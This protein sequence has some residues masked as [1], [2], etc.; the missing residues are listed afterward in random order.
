M[1]SFVP[2]TVNPGRDFIEAFTTGL[3]IGRGLKKRAAHNQVGKATGEAYTLYRQ[4]REDPAKVTSENM[5]KV[6][7]L[8]GVA[9]S[10]APKAGLSPREIEKMFPQWDEMLLDRTT[11]LARVAVASGLNSDEGVASVA[12]ITTLLSGK[13]PEAI[14][15]QDDGSMIVVPGGAKSEE[16]VMVLNEQD[17]TDL[18]DSLSEGGV[19]MS[20]MQVQLRQANDSSA[21]GRGAP[22]SGALESLAALEGDAAQVL[23]NRER[24]ADRAS[25][26]Q[27]VRI[28]AG[29]DLKTNQNTTDASLART[30][31]NDRATQ[32]R[33][34]ANIRTTSTSQLNSKRGAIEDRRATEQRAAEAEQLSLDKKAQREQTAAIQARADR[35]AYDQMEIDR[36]KADASMLTAQTGSRAEDR[37]TEAAPGVASRAERAI[38]VEEGKLGLREREL[39]QSK[40]PP[41]LRAFAQRN[42]ADSIASQYPTVA[43]AARQ[44]GGLSPFM[45]GVA[46]RFAREGTPPGV[47]LNDT[48]SVLNFLEENSGQLLSP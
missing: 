41:S 6:D 10:A 14:E 34:R 48:Q 42:T 37:M 47:N 26:D 28:K 4:M 5:A 9:I 40:I 3:E 11:N 43:E 20:G 32:Q 13:E 12:A 36:Q 44:F 30:A 46:E 1:A 23:T 22:K 27:N 8:L 29:V 15:V 16:D 2:I 33:E 35:R 39:I 18:T 17:L 38:A 31:S 45:M 19:S 21:K 24:A 25:N 7:K